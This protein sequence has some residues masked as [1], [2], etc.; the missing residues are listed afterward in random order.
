[1]ATKPKFSQRGSMRARLA[2]LI[3]EQ[4]RG[5]PRQLHFSELSSQCSES[6]R[7]AVDD[8]TALRMTVP[9][10]GRPRPAPLDVPTIEQRLSWDEW[11]VSTSGKRTRRGQ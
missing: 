8:A 11:H 1:M 9:P 6:D 10:L 5:K 3:A 4:A 7:Y 2:I